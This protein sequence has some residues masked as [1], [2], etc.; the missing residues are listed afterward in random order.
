[1]KAEM[2]RTAVMLA[3]AVVLTACAGPGTTLNR[4]DR[5]AL[6]SQPHIHA[7]HHHPFRVFTVESTAR[8]LFVPV[9]ISVLE[10]MAIQKDYKLQDPAPRIKD[11]LAAVL[12]T[13]FGLTNVRVVSESPE[14][15]AADTLRSTYKDGVVLDVRT[16]NWGLDNYRAT[17]Q[18]RARLIR[19]ADGVVIWQET[20]K[21][22]VANR[23]KPAAA[24]E[25][26]LANDAELLKAQLRQAADGCADE[27]AG[28]LRK[29]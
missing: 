15:D 24:M 5:M 25:A 18:A 2:A 27:L 9:P 12:Q 11:R 3:A 23:G 13:D 1:M 29:G 7:V 16:W 21:T 14:A 26:L 8:S 10:G 19:L 20:C 28:L 4:D 17:Y 22:S 6:A